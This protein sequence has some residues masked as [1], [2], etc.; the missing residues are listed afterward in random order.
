MQNGSAGT[1]RFVPVGLPT[2]EERAR[3]VRLWPDAA[4]LWRALMLAPTYEVFDAL[5]SGESVP[6]ESLDPVWVE[7]LGRRR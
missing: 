6:I 4:R 5:M 3:L 7:R 1:G 2:A